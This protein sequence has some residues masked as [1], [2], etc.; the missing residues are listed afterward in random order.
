LC[1]VPP[2]DGKERW[3]IKEEDDRVTLW[4]QVP[5][6]SAKDIE[7]TTT[8]QVLEI[9]RKVATT[10]SGNG[11]EAADVHGVGAF[12]IRLL[13][14][15]QYDAN[16]VTADLKD[17][18]LEVIVYKDQ[19]SKGKTVKLGARPPGGDDASRRV[20]DDERKLD[21]NNKKQKAGQ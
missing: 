4:L 17:G 20:S 5:G 10:G 3:D 18:M 12:H 15:G 11:K 13:M 6:V 2:P 14:T 8:E 9:K 1:P 7:V 21:K 19:Q 16:K